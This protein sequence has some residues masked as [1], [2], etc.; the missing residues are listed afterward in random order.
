M[1][2]MYVFS[3]V[4]FL[5]PSL[6]TQFSQRKIFATLPFRGQLEDQAKTLM[7][8]P[9][10]VA[11]FK[12]M[13]EKLL[14]VQSTSD[15]RLET[16]LINIE[17]SNDYNIQTIAD[18]RLAMSHLLSV[19]ADET[20]HMELQR[21]VNDLRESRSEISGKSAGVSVLCGY[22]VAIAGIALVLIF[23]FVKESSYKRGAFSQS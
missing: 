6:L 9:E 2:N 18:L 21:Q 16:A 19:G 5:L 23:H 7:P 10:T 14:L 20:R 17:N 15:C 4:M 13:D 11:L 12:A 3:T 22:L 1:Q 8:R